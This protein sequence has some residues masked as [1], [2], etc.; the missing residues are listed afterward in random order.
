MS[1]LSVVSGKRCFGTQHET[2]GN[3]PSLSEFELLLVKFLI[4]LCI[5]ECVGGSKNS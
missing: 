3:N 1:K 4:R 2:F 5:F